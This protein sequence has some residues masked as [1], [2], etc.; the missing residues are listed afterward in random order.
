M[1][2]GF[3]KAAELAVG[4]V[5]PEDLERER[6]ELLQFSILSDSH[7]EGPFRLELQ[8]ERINRI[9]K[10]KYTLISYFFLNL[11]DLGFY[12]SCI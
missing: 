8:E 1:A 10:I 5:A 4:E 6:F 11:L 12:L 7:R 3:E 9:I 2:A